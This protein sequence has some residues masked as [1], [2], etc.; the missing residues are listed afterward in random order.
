MRRPVLAEATS[1]PTCDFAGL[2]SIIEAFLAEHGSAPRIRAGCFGVAG[3]VVDQVAELTNVP[4]TIS[5][6]RLMREFDLQH[7]RLLNDLEAMAHAV[8]VLHDDE[9]HTLQRGEP[10]PDGNA[11][12]IAAGTG[13]GESVLHRVDGRLRPMA[14][15]GGHTDFAARHARE[16]ALLQALLRKSD[17]VSVEHV[18]SGP[19]IVNLYRFT[20]G[21]HPCAAAGDQADMAKAPPRISQA[22][23]EGACPRCVE[24]M[25]MFA[26]AYGAEAGNLALRAMS[27]SGLYLGGGIAPKILPLL[28]RG[29]F[30]AAFRDKAPMDDLV[31]SMPVQVILNP[32]A[33]LLGAAVFANGTV[34]GDR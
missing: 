4:W 20:H 16:T 32:H 17:R 5:A 11:A 26:A 21:D 23:M 9:L 19:G 15:E 24:T 10:R 3:P 29:P 22:A 28:E 14:T 25:D 1:F 33:A 7:V 13:L 30:L 27:T 34:I 18:V 8:P 31:A 12:L 2:P 6:D